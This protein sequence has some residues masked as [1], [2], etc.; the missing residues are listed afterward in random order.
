MKLQTIRFKNYKRPIRAHHNDSGADCFAAETVI[1]PAHGVAKVP[2]GVGV[3]L[4][5]GYDIVVHC[6]SGLSSNGIWAANAP[7]DAGYTGE[8]HAI[9]YN[10][11]D[12]NFEIK[13]G[14]KVGQFVVR[15]VVYVDFVEELDQDSRGNAGFGSTGR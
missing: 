4:P 3:K 8:I 1:I 15:P 7:V 14:D 12:E 11:T 13:A 10:T 9:L 5:D 6:K 2:T